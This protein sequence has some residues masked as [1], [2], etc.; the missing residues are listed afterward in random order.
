MKTKNFYFLVNM[1]TSFEQRILKGIAAYARQQRPRWRV[2]WGRVLDD[3]GAQEVDG[4]IQFAAEPEVLLDLLKLKLPIV[5]TSSRHIS[6]GFPCVT[7][8]DTAI[9]ELAAQH[10]REK[11][12]QSFAFVGARDVG[13]SMSRRE[14]FARAVAPAEVQLLTL[15]DYLPLAIR[16]KK[17][18]ADL[19]ALPPR[20]AVFT[21]NDVYAR[22]VLNALEGSVRQVPGDISVMG[23]DADELISLSCPMDLSSVDSNPEGIGAKAAELMG[24]I[25]EEP[26]SVPDG[27]LHRVQPRGIVEGTSTDALATDDELVLRAR[28]LMRLRACDREYTIADLAKEAGCSRRSLELRFSAASGVGLGQHLWK[29]RI[30][31]A[32]ELLRTTTL[33]LAE[34]AEQSGFVSQFH[35]SEKFKKETGVPPG[36]YRKRGD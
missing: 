25:L 11:F 9:S 15:D 21:A 4:V 13:F 28:E 32:K 2:R 24:Q 20:T 30:D 10:F 35:F 23:V 5:S 8:N 31:H 27:F 33:N 3:A 12:Y 22:M 36:H 1:Q 14:A 7:T 17:F 18:Q 16:L 19:E 26:G 34:V 6:A 29:L